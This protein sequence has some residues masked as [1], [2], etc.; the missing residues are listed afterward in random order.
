V[1]AVFS[2]ESL[3]L[4]LFGS[5]ICGWKAEGKIRR[6]IKIKNLREATKIAER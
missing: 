1:V 6:S 4:T 2:S 3:T 5:F